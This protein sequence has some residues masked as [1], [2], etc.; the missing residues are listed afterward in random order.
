MN[1]PS[2]PVALQELTFAY[3]P[4][5]RHVL[6]RLTIALPPGQVTAILG[7]NGAGKTTLLR[8]IL[9]YLQ[10]QAGD[11]LIGGRKLR[12]IPHRELSQ[13]VGL[14][15]QTET[16]LFDY[17]VLEFVLLGRAPYL[18]PLE[19]PGE[20]DCQIAMGALRELH[21]EE[22]AG[23]PVPELSGGERQMVLVARALTQQTRILLLD[24]PTSHLDLSNKGRILSVMQRLA[25]RGVTVVFTTHDPEAAVA[26][27]QHLILVRN[28]QVLDHG[29]LADVLT[30][31]KMEQ[32]YG[33]PVRIDFIDGTPVV[34]L[35]RLV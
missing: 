23:R 12:Q 20:T 6:D 32:T 35:P 27:A 1:M 25:Q 22:L 24:E 21:I 30:A 11:I 34:R 29:P 3:D 19:M 9:G 17:T 33:V 31:E 18:N 16:I 5:G 8:L 14:V 10:P 7:P 13:I 2:L 26:V 28:G 4:G 15:P